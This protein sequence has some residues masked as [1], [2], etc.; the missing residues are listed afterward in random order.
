MKST[1]PNKWAWA[2]TVGTV[3]DYC[4][5][6]MVSSTWSS[7]LSQSDMG[8]DGS[9]PERMATKWFLEFLITASAML[10]LCYSGGTNSS[11]HSMQI[12]P[13]IL[14]EHSLSKTCLSIWV[15]VFF[16]H[17]IRAM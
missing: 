11:L 1:V 5:K 15:P 9:V 14:S 6:L 8:K 16:T 3:L 12:I 10:C 17:V 2:E 7:S 4:S 13:L